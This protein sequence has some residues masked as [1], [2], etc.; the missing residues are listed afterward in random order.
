M[1]YDVADDVEEVDLSADVTCVNWVKMWISC[2]SREYHVVCFIYI[3]ILVGN[4]THSY[5]ILKSLLSIHF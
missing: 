2:M 3:V 5:G 1:Q 4:S